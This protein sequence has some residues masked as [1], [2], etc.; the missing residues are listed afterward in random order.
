MSYNKTM[1]T[2]EPIPAE[3]ESV[4]TL[5]VD[6]VYMVYSR[7][8]PGLLESVYEACLEYELTQR[9]I[10]VQRQVSIPICYGELKIDGGFRIDL[11][12]GGCLIVELKAVDSLLPVH[13]SQVLTYLKL[14]RHRLGLLINFNVPLIRYGIKRVVL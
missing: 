1:L 3:V 13:R 4:A 5:V 6:A 8:G 7:L 14:T 12:V 11:Y 9:G 10:K 2:R